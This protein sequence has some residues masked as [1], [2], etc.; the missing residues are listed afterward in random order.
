MMRALVVAP[1]FP[2]PSTTG[3]RLRAAEWIA[4]LS[5]AGEVTLVAPPGLPPLVPRGV[6]HVVA[7]PSGAGA[8]AAGLSTV[9]RR[10]PLHDALAGRLDWSGALGAIRGE[11][12]D[13][14]VCVLTRTL[15]WIETRALAARTLVDAVDALSRSREERARRARGPV[16]WFWRREARLTRER[17]RIVAREADAVVVVGE[18]ERAPF[19]GRAEVIPVGVEL[20]PLD[21]SARDIDCAFWGRLGF[22]ANRD[23]AELLLREVWPAVRASLPASRLLLA[24]ADAPVSLLD[25]HG[26]DGIE[27]LSP[28]EDRA[29][30]LRRVRVA[31]LPVRFGTGQSVKLLEACEAG[32]AVAALPAAL[33]GVSFPSGAAEACET[34]AELAAA[35]VRLL[36]EPARAR[37]LAAAGRAWVARDYDREKTRARMRELVERVIGG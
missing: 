16:R 8:L 35:V 29:R 6:R 11:R 26:R 23:A 1:R 32:L 19:D 10:L 33:R 36:R 21:D 20:R 31:V 15:P 17:E 37:E 9:A 5:S 34:P 12:F 22:F 28:M 7:V 25:A 4:A 13:V 2:W 24:G 3:D 14:A 27:V 18:A 30:L